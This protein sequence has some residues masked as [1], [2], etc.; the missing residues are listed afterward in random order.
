LSALVCFDGVPAKL[1]IASE[2]AET[3]R[4]TPMKLRVVIN[5]DLEK[6]FFFIVSKKKEVFAD[7]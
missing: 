1:S 4:R 5:P 3:H 6:G 2:I 7:P